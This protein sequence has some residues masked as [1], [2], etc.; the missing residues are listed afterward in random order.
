V[1]E[2]AAIREL[3]GL[4]ERLAPRQCTVLLLGESGT[5]KELVARHLHG[6]SPRGD[7][8]FVP[9]DC[10]NLRESLLESQLFGHVRGAFTGAESDTLGCVRA[11]DGGTLF[12][13]EIAELPLPIQAKLLRCIQERAVTPLG[14]VKSIPVDVRIIAATHRN[15]ERMSAE[16]DFRRDLF[17]RLNVAAIRLPPLRA[18]S[19][20]VPRLVSHFLRHQAELYGETAKRFD[21]DSLRTLLSYHWPGNVRELANAVEHSYVFC[22]DVVITA[23]YLPEAIRAAGNPAAPAATVGLD[24]ESVIPLYLAEKSLIER[25]L[26]ASRGNQSLA[27]RML[28]IDRRR[29]S[30]K[31]QMHGLGARPVAAGIRPAAVQ[32]L[33]N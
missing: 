28:R 32:P 33:P 13:D 21:G 23:Q 17:Y 5:G 25:A 18:R 8:P 15:L 16:G 19:E 7:K 3:L 30:R 6:T 27:A 10:T 1:G 29:L 9:V 20:D 12:F 24:S 26:R 11:A 4:I 14:S 31:I 22:P 2:S